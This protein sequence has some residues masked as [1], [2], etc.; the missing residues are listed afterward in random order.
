MLATPL[1]LTVLGET[2]RLLGGHAARAAVAERL[3]N[4]AGNASARAA[5]RATRAQSIAAAPP[6]ATA[7][8]PLTV[9]IILQARAG[10]CRWRP[11]AP[12]GT[13]APHV[14]HLATPHPPQ[15]RS[16]DVLRS[17]RPVSRRRDVFRARTHTGARGF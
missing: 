12:R 7:R 13:L 9:E 2:R 8:G 6:A 15:S 5:S 17:G 1:R 3:T 14:V 10:R 16:V 4:S 11:A